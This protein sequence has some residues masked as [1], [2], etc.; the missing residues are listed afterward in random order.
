M[1]NFLREQLTIF[2]AKQYIEMNTKIVIHGPCRLDDGKN[3]D[4]VRRAI[5][6]RR[7]QN[8]VRAQYLE[9]MKQENIESR[10]QLDRRSTHFIATMN[11][12]IIACVRLTPAPFEM[13]LL[14]P[15]LQQYQA[16][17]YQG[18]FEFGRLCTDVNLTNKGE[19]AKYLLIKAGLWAMSAPRSRGLVGICKENKVRF[20]QKFGLNPIERNLDIIGREGSYTLIGAERE[21]IM[22]FFANIYVSPFINIGQSVSQA[23]QWRMR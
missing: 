4:L 15:T 14:N 21:Q 10:L 5:S 7:Q 8:I 3:A 6:F 20:M 1:K 17:R 2:L 16:Q 22:D 13:S 11:N 18:Y 23:L 12:R 9:D 19:V